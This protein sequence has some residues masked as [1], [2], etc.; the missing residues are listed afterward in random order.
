MREIAQLGQA[1]DLTMSAQRC[2][3]FLQQ[4]PQNA[5]GWH[6]LSVI[7]FQQQQWQPALEYIQTALQL[8]P[9]RAEFL[10]QAGV[11]LCSMGRVS[12]GMESYQQ[13]LVLQPDLSHTRFNLG[14]ALQKQGQFDRAQQTYRELLDRQPDYALAHL[15]LGNIAQQQKQ[16]FIAIDHYRQAVAQTPHLTIAWCNLGVALQ[17][18]GDLEAAQAAFQT[19][20]S[21]NPDYAEAH[22]GLGAIYERQEQSDAARHHY[23]QALDRQPDHLPALI[24]WANLHLRLEEFAIAEAALQQ[25]LQRQPDRVAALDQLIKISLLT[26][27][28]D[29]WQ[30]RIATFYQAFRAASAQYS[31]HQLSDCLVAPLNSL[32]LPFSA[33]EQQQIAQ[34]YAQ[35]LETQTTSLKQ[36]FQRWIAQQPNRADRFQPH[37]IRLGYVSGDFR[38]HAVGQLILRLFE[39]HDR[40]QF[41]V[42]AYSLGPDDG[43]MERRKFERDCDR[44]QDVKG[45]TAMAIA[46]QIYLDQIDILID[47]AGYTNYACPELFALR[48]APLQVNYLGYPGTLGATYIDYVVTD[49]TI[50]P[51]SL[52]DALTETCLYLPHTYQLNCYP[53]PESDQ[54][55]GVDSSAQQRAEAGFAELAAR[56]ALRQ[57]QGL[58]ID[59]FVFCC[60]NKVQ[61]IEPTIFASW[62]RILVQVPDSVLWLLSDRPAVETQ[63]RAQAAQQ[64]IAP[65]R[66][67]FA[68][69]LPKVQHL[70]RLSAADL[71]LDTRYYNAH[72]TAS[73]ALWA[74]VPVITILGETFASRVGASL[75]QAV[76]LPDLITHSLTEYE[77]LAVCLATDR[78]ALTAVQQL[79]KQARSTGALF[80]TAQTIRDLETGYQLIWQRHQAGLAPAAITI[81]RELA[82]PD[83]SDAISASISTL[84]STLPSVESSSQPLPTAQQNPSIA[85]ARS[86]P[87]AIA[88][89]HQITCVADAGFQDWLTQMQGSLLI[90]TYQAGKVLL[91]GCRQQQITLT[92]RSFQRPMGVAVS[93]DRL[94]LATQ[95]GVLLFSNARALAADYPGATSRYDG[96]Y[97]PRSTYWT[98]DLYTHDLS[99]GREGLWLVNTRFSCL[100]HL[101]LDFSFVPRWYP[102]FISAL[103]PE[104]RCHL[105]GLAMVE[106]QPKYV[107]AL[108][109]SNQPNGWRSGKSIGGVL[110]EVETDRILR[111]DLSM[112]HSPRWHQDRLW[113]L[114]SGAGELWCVD[115]QTGQHQVVCRLPGFGRGLALVGN[116]AVVGLSQFR[117]RSTQ[118]SVQGETDLPILAQS[119][120][121]IC[122]V[123]IV[124]LTRGQPI[125]RL[126]FSSGCQELFD[127]QFLPQIRQA[128]LL[129]PDQSEAQLAFTAPE[130]AYWLRTSSPTSAA[131]RSRHSPGA[132]P[133]RRS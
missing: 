102:D 131:E 62:M 55:V 132:N 42:Y 96:L 46:Q 34:Q 116:Y 90:T 61:K 129:L 25:I 35:I 73:D 118:F 24:N 4:H 72:V 8:A 50:A 70:Q 107:T 27:R 3:Q 110:I 76:G 37:K 30:D 115:P 105:N 16:F 12:D 14:L 51:P 97:L 40:Q 80:D 45:Q 87:E 66:L 26:V 38:Y 32:Y 65:D 81:D 49:R 109:A 112:P 82:F 52:S 17:A 6:L 21:Q 63:L 68:A 9:D 56:N 44:F 95:T 64:G 99:F 133:D 106:G 18:I 28:W 59:A 47:L 78:A 86:L 127:V 121:L 10:S 5:D 113:L 1:G 53:Y 58:P 2:Q 77:Q 22:N 130:F 123:V 93:G 88:P 19:A 36:Q 43:S 60:F 33:I 69:R 79:L 98:G 101:S 91:V 117:D 128:N 119:D 125:G 15:Q 85:L 20:L 120:R 89:D 7:R 126:E 84:M 54:D 75:L 48:P 124:D 67:R 108:G 92:A 41:E 71:F 31:P 122:G 83:R 74:G 94:A 111:G 103:T 104:D 11:V 100:A 29:D 57:S 39:W 13:A 114:N 23:C